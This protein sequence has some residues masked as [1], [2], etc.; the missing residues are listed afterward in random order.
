MR[1]RFLLTLTVVALI[2]AMLPGS[3][4]AKKGGE[5]ANPDKANGYYLSLGTSLAAGTLADGMGGSIGF[6]PSSYT[7][8]LAGRLAQDD[9][10][11]RKH[12]K[13]GCP[14]ETTL[15]MMTGFDPDGSPSV[16]HPGVLDTYKT[17]TQLGDALAHLSSGKGK[18]TKLITIDM[19]A[20]DALQTLEACVTDLACILGD[21]ELTKANL[22]SIL[23]DIREV[24]DGP[25][26]AMNYYNPNLVAWFLDPG[27]A[28][29]TA[30]LQS[31]YND[32]LETVYAD[33]DVLLA[34]VE[35]AFGSSDFSDAN[36]N[37]VPDNV[38]TI[39]ALTFM[40]SDDNIHPTPVGYEFIAGVFE[41]TMAGAGL[42]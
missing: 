30:A 11:A 33:F 37:F 19:G 14:G 41:A 35:V 8:F 38:E 7:D 3:A 27:L 18:Q 4:I 20:N 9:F 25:I 1:K 36:G 2:F 32:G 13:L 16:C 17:G 24:Y 15:S 39:C 22:R 34:D 12:V 31:L 23:A 42:L 28:A 40:C 10:K 6:S 5:K 26:V 21:L 29:L